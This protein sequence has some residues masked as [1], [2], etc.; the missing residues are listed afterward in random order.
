MVVNHTMIRRIYVRGGQLFAH[1]HP[2]CYSYRI[3]KKNNATTYEKIMCVWF[4]CHLLDRYTAGT[5]RSSTRRETIRCFTKKNTPFCSQE[6]S[7]SNL[8]YV[9]F[10]SPLVHRC[11]L[12]VTCIHAARSRTYIYIHTQIY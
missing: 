5:V 8:E 10:C 4:V 3:L 2:L 7:I 1:I 11:L 6:V 12:C 9:T